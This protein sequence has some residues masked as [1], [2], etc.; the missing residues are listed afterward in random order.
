[1][2]HPQQKTHWD[3]DH[4]IMQ[5]PYAQT[6]EL[7]MEILKYGSDVEVLGPPSLRSEIQSMLATALA[8]YQGRDRQSK[9][10]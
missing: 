2:W 9:L 1:V 3:G 5:L 6:R 8:R 4:L 10:L 7:A